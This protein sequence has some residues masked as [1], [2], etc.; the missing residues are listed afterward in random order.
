MSTLSLSS[1]LSP[2]AITLLVF[3]LVVLFLGATFNVQVGPESF[4][5]GNTTTTPKPTTAAAT[6]P[7]PTTAAATTKKST[8]M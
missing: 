8:L 1:I 2:R 4:V 6:T 3:I 7:K 5:E